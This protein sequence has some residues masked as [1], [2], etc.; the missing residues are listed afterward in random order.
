MLRL[1]H[2]AARDLDAAPHAARQ[3]LHL[4]VGPRRELHR[5]E[6]LVAS[7]AVRLSRGTPY[8]LAKMSRFSSTLSSRSLVIAC[9][10]T[11]ID[12]AHAVG[13]RDDV[14]A[15]DARRARRRREERGQ[16]ADERRLAG[17]VRARAGRRSRPP[18]P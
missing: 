6:Q 14:E 16:H 8:S 4:L 5:L 3:I 2:Q 18:R 12:S 17:A 11:P 10:M 9:G 7:A 1:V 15:V 13:L